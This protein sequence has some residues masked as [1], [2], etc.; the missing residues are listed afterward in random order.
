MTQEQLFSYFIDLC[1]DLYYTWLTD[2]LVK[3]KCIPTYYMKLVPA[4]LS[5]NV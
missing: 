3:E 4:S 1:Y 5:T 2:K